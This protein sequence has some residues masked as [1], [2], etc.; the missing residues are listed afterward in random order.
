METAMTDTITID[1]AEYDRLLEA[2]EDLADIRVYD[3]LKADI[4]SGVDELI[5]AEFVDRMLA[6]EAPV[7]VWRDYR[8][9]T[10]Q[11]LSEASGVNRVQIANIESGVR[12]GSVATMRKLAAALGVAIDDL[13]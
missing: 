3:R 2:S 6:G 9:L 5:P 1:R 13:V 8:G 7:R 4:S 12:S 11:Q 10:Q